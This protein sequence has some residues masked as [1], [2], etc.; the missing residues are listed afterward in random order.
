MMRTICLY[1]QIHQPFHLK[2]YRFFDIGNEHYYYDDYANESHL[3]K[4]V[5]MSYLPANKILSELIEKSKGKFKVAFSIS[6]DALDQFELYAPEVLQSFKDL[7]QTGMVEFLAETNSH[8]LVSLINKTE[9]ERQVNSHRERIKKY[10]GQE[11]KVFRNTELIY[12]DQLGADIAEMG[13]EGMITEGAKH[14]LGWK[15]P[16]YLYCNAINPRLKVLLRNFRLSD[17][18]S[19]RFGVKSWNEYPLTADKFASWLMAVDP[20]EENINIFFDYETFGYR[21]RK[22][23]GIF[24]FLRHF[25]GAV[26]KHTNYSFSTPGE[27]VRNLQPIAP[28]SV[29]TP[30]SWTD[31]ERDLTSWIGNDLQNEAFRKLYDL[32][33]LVHKCN[34][35]RIQ[36]DW[37]YL[38]ASDHFSYMSTKFFSDR[39]L[40][41]GN[42]F[43]SPYD[44]FINYMNVLSDF[45]LRVQKTL[46]LSQPSKGHDVDEL[47]RIIEEK[48]TLLAH[49][50]SE[51]NKVGS[52]IPKS[53]SEKSKK[54]ST[55]EASL[56]KSEPKAQKKKT[57]NPA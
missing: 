14:I 35:P 29:P 23:T 8:S 54:I 44:A 36:I 56:P 7:A 12:S 27:V 57:L 19:F 47:L 20:R 3:R 38:Q 37:K 15:S 52:K 31:E 21:Q 1:F 13:F 6:G 50:Q 30:I 16:N 41:G 28:V 17:D 4:V 48:D 25:P 22:E 10:F 45:T 24:D 11:P 18:L 53:K 32:N 39:P 40:K 26:L 5:E 2:R 42:P 51:L 34:D 49:Y 33:D 46:K 43:G 55:K 9:F